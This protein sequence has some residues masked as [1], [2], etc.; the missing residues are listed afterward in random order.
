MGVSPGI[1]GSRVRFEQSRITVSSSYPGDYASVDWG[2]K[3]VPNTL[4]SY[5]ELVS[6]QGPFCGIMFAMP[7]P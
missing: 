7:S 1:F 3:V 5:L 4:Y 2:P 6:L